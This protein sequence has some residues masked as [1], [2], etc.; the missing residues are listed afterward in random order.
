MQVFRFEGETQ[1]TYYAISIVSSDSSGIQTAVDSLL[2]RF[3]S[4]ASVYKPN[5]I[6]SRINSNDSSILADET[7]Q[8]IFTKAMEVSGITNGA[9]D[10][11]VG[12]LV[13]AWGFGL[14]NRMQMD[15]HRVDSLLAF[16]GYTKIRMEG[17]RL[18]KA[19]PRIRIDY[20]AIAQGY[21]VDLVGQFL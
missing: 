13:N 17:Q 4:S 11:T 19:D 16:V 3:D 5:S 7:F 14:S 20:N 9:F 10:I 18:V 1:G 21:A 2:H 15:Q 12:P 8:T 6:I